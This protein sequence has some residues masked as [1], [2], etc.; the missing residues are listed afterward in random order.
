VTATLGNAMSPK[1]LARIA[2]VFYAMQFA[3]APGMYAA[4]RLVVVGDAATTAANIV[5]HATVFQLG[6]A[7]NLIAI[8][9]YI[10]VTALFYVLFKPVNRT[11]SLLAAFL[12]LAGCIVIAVGT[13][14]YISPLVLLG[15]A[16]A[17][18]A[19]T[20]AQVQALALILIGLYGQSFNLSF[21]FFG[22]YCLLIGYLTLTS[23]FLPRILGAGMMLAGLCWLTFLW[24]PL[25]HLV[26][27][28]ILLGG[29][30]EMALAIWLLVAGVNSELWLEQAAA[31][32][33]R[34][35]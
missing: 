10:A 17:S 2:G 29:I 3:F 25:M 5:G 21:V 8:A 31:A 32:A 4:R 34:P 28:Y 7:G 16:H 22:F 24:P 33:S 14:L 6:F 27:S 12:S 11:V 1:R 35:L 9:T 23:T 19:F 15:G 20:V 30:G 18:S 26:S 13:A